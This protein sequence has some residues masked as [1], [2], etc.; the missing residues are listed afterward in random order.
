MT[1]KERPHPK[2]PELLGIIPEG[3][4]P[5]KDGLYGVV[6]YGNGDF[7]IVYQ[8]DKPAFGGYIAKESIYG[9]PDYCPN[10]TRH[11][12]KH[13]KKFG[14]MPHLVFFDNEQ[15]AQQAGFRACRRCL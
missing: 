12:K 15:T 4:A 11:H 7:N 2:Q 5:F 8:S 9:D 10:A 3:Y 13:Y 6:C 1:Y 14:T